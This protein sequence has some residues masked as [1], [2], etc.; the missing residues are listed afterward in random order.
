MHCILARKPVPICNSSLSKMQS[1][2][3]LPCIGHVPKYS[4]MPL[5][6]KE[7]MCLQDGVA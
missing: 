2:N 3:L 7:P 5:I 6:N 1:C 4:M